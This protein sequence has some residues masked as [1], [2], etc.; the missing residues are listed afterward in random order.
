MVGRFGLSRI[1]GTLMLTLAALGGGVAAVSA[2]SDYPN[3]PIE[4]VTPFAAGGAGDG[5]ARIF[6]QFLGQKL[7]QQVNVINRAGGNTIPAVVSIVNA[8]PDGYTLLWDGPA[9]S[10]IQMSS[11]DLPYDV[12]DRW[13]G[14]R[15][16]ASPYYIAVPASSSYKT[17][18]D[19]VEAL[20]TTPKDIDIAW[21]GGISMTDTVLLSF[22]DVIGVKLSDVTLVPFTGSGPAATA[23]AGGHIDVALGAIPAVVPLYQAGSVRV[24]ALAGD[25]RL[26][27]F[28]DVPS[29]AEAGHLVPLTGW[30]ALGGPKGIPDAVAAKLDTAVKE[31]T[32]DPEFA[33]ALDG[34]SYVPTYMTPEQNLAEIKKEGEVL[35]AIRTAAGV[36]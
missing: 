27:V 32:G 36:N 8:A 21:L 20:K 4:L 10:S 18:G 14:S 23:L 30:N 31:I 34:F 11:K 3:K 6:A 29:S 28:P 25:Q 33:K 16:N 2:Q 13:F 12:L 24:L 19:L 22:L 5:S 1:A 35:G 9:T 15:V 26:A 7:G 17:L